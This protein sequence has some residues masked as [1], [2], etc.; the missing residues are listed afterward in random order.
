MDETGFLPVDSPRVIPALGC[1]SE[2]WPVQAT[3]K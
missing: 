3:V 2:R 1:R